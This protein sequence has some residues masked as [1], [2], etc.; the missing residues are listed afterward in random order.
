MT[1]TANKPKYRRMELSPTLPASAKTLIGPPWP[2]EYMQRA[3][4]YRR[5]GASRAPHAFFVRARRRVQMASEQLRPM[6]VAARWR[7]CNLAYKPILS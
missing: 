4:L 3:T 7:P 1:L 5:V 6:V 2:R